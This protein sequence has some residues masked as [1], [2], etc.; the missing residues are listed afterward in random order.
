MSVRP[1]RKP[2]AK[3]ARIAPLATLPLFHRLD[4]R[5]VVVAGQGDAVVWK[6]ELVAAAGADVLVLAG[7][8]AGRFAGL[9][10]VAGSIAVEPR[11]WTEADLTGAVLAL[12]DIADPAESAAFI[13]AAHA[14]G[15]AVNMI[16]RTELCDVLFGTVVNRSPV[17]VGISTDGAAPALGQSV[18]VRIESVLP[19]GLARWAQAARDWRPRVK[20]AVAEFT[21]RRRFW[22]RFARAAWDNIDRAP[23]ERDF[24]ALLADTAAAP[25][26]SVILVGAG[27]GDPE[28]LTLKAVRA[29]QT[30]T[31]ILYDD[32]VG[33]EVL[34]LARREA[35]RIAVGKRGGGPSVAQADICAQIVALAQAG[36]TVVRL[37]GGD[38]GIFGRATEEID[39]CRAAGV[40]VSIVPG[41]TAAQA[42]AAS[43]GISLTERVHARRV[44]FVTGHGADGHLPADLDW[45]ALADPAATTVIYMP[46]KTLAAFAR[47]AIAAGLDPATPALAVA[48]VARAGQR[49]VTAPVAALA[50]ELVRLP[51]DAPVTVIVGQVTRA[52][53]APVQEL[54]A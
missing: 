38:P 44:Q 49:H 31:V 14:A 11:G 24:D 26:G 48:S 33:A 52:L 28:L 10:P 25:G 5:K 20:A 8:G 50:A 41:V 34:E 27:P 39:A 16:D 36:E 1:I 54:A 7:D 17:V 35:T 2:E 42:A 12:G 53:A 47:A 19:P 37:K 46:K 45:Q 4:G 6:A 21:E 51:A 13:A 30:A 43:L 23:G 15:A 18:R 3:P 32:L 22:Q 9:T 29:L 40:A